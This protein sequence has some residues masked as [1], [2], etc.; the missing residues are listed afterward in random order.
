M[1]GKKGMA[2]HAGGGIVRGLQTANSK[3]G[4][5]GTAKLTPKKS[6]GA[7]AGKATG[8]RLDKRA[9]GGATPKSPLTNAGNVKQPGFVQG[10]APAQDQGGSGRD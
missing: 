8:G 2:K 10:S 1:K 9:R 6:G 5:Q 3:H 7:I 4:P